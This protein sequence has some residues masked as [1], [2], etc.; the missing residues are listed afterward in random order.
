MRYVLPSGQEIVILIGD[1]KGLRREH[2][3]GAIVSLEDTFRQLGRCYGYETMDD[4]IGDCVRNAFRRFGEL[5]GK[6]PGDGLESVIF[7]MLGAG[8]TDI[9]VLEI[10]LLLLR[11]I[12]RGVERTPACKTV[13]VSAWLETHRLALRKAAEKLELTET[14]LIRPSIRRFLGRGTKAETAGRGSR[15]LRVLGVR[16]HAAPL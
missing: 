9:R 7:P 10:A 3:I 6:G 12:V 5:A 2:G 11:H 8:T 1:A 16:T 14:T 15:V 4:M 13:Y